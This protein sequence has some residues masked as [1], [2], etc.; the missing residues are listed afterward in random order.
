LTSLLRYAAVWLLRGYVAGYAFSGS[1]A[2]MRWNTTVRA[3]SPGE[4]S[5]MAWV[6]ANTPDSSR[7]LVFDAGAP[8]FGLDP[9]S[10][11]LPAI[12]G[13]TSVNT[14]QGYEWLPR[15][16]FYARRRRYEALH[17]CA[18]RGVA[19]IEQWLTKAPPVGF[20]YL[21]DDSCCS[22]LAASLRASPRYV[23]V[24][25]QRGTV[26]FRRSPASADLR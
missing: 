20:V 5:A 14:V 2:A 24:F 11:W 22:A 10:E 23:P 4:R 25:E 21:H 7:F 1:H 3:L 12:T 6:A 9:A 16:Q 15:R 26:I 18:G 17:S 8:W 13:R 19:C